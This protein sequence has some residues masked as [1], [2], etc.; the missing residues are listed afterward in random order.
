MKT[1]ILVFAFKKKI[2]YKYKPY[3][4]YIEVIISRKRGRMNTNKCG[5]VCLRT[6]GIVD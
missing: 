4:N 1:A 2:S 5:I 6:C 3:T